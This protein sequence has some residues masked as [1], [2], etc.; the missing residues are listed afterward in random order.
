MIEGSGKSTRLATPA[1]NLQPPS[2]FP[3]SPFFFFY[4]SYNFI[5]SFVR[6]VP[7]D[8][9]LTFSPLLRSGVFVEQQTLPKACPPTLLSPS[10]LYPAFP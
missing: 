9:L 10:L 8:F 1:F 2:P 6:I 7:G 5:L 3:P 4:S